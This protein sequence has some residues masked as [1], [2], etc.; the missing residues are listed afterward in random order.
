MVG[1]V[2]CCFYGEIPLGPETTYSSDMASFSLT[3]LPASSRICCQTNIRY[4][5]GRWL[6][7]YQAV[8]K[9]SSN[10]CSVEHDASK[11][12]LPSVHS[13]L[14]CS[15]QKIQQ[16][17]GCAENT[18]ILLRRALSFKTGRSA[19]LITI[20][21]IKKILSIKPDCYSKYLGIYLTKYS[22]T[23]FKNNYLL[24]SKKYNFR[25]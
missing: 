19:I 25:L 13:I 15:S 18:I 21:I 10:T 20:L 3:V 6:A 23:L 2:V 8:V 4:K 12:G 14:Y 1:K 22:K 11:A 16:C 24:I 9:S 17:R 5:L 7:K